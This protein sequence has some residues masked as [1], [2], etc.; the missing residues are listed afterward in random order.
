MGECDCEGVGVGVCEELYE[1]EGVCDALKDVEAELEAVGEPEFVTV[2][3]YVMD[4]EEDIDAVLEAVPELE[5]EGEL[6]AVP[7]GVDECDLRRADG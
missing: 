2:A 7:V 6:L 4:D 3:L 5:L 1:C